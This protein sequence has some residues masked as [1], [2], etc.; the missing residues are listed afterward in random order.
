MVTFYDLICL[1]LTPTS[2][3]RSVLADSVN[4]TMFT[5]FSYF[6]KTIAMPMFAVVKDEICNIITVVYFF[7]GT[8]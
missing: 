7:L 5:L 1:L 2:S 4:T 3:D 6:H 8:L